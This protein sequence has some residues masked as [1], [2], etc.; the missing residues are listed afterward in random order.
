[1]FGRFARSDVDAGRDPAGQEKGIGIAALRIAR[2]DPFL[3][4][5][6]RAAA[7]LPGR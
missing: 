2:G 6:Q 1:L 5:E 4:L 7:D 3:D